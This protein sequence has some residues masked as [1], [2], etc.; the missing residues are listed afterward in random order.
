MITNRKIQ[1]IT[2][3][4]IKD[5]D[6]TLIELNEIY[7]QTGFIFVANQGKFTRIKKEIKH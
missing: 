5:G 2:L 3:S 7:K 1:D 6:V 4:N